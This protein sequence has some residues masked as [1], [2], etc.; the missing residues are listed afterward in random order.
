[1]ENTGA[2]KMWIVAYALWLRRERPD[3]FVGGAYTPLF[4]TGDRSEHMVGYARGRTGE[5]PQVIVAATRYSL[6]LTEGGWSDTV[7]DL[8]SGTWTDRFTG[9]TFNGRTRLE[10]LFARLPVA[11]LVR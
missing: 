3:C 4:A 7:L 5:P 8:P 9:H 6:A 10:K 2:A 11:L 1:M